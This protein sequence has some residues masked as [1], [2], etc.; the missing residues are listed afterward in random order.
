M[1]HTLHLTYVEIGR[2]YAALR[3]AGATRDRACVELGATPE[4]MRPFERRLGQARPGEGCDA[5]RP[6]FARCG[7]HVAAVLRAGGYPVLAR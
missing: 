4:A 3:L 5:V 2:T 1:E 7:A 6:R